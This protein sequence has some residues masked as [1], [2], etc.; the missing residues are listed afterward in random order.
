[1]LRGLYQ[2]ASDGG[3]DMV[4]CDYYEE[5]E[6]ERIYCPQSPREA[7]NR[8]LMKQIA[9]WGEFLPC[10]WNKL[11]KTEI[12]KKVAFPRITFSE[13][14]VIMFQVLFFCKSIGYVNKAFYHWCVIPTSVSRNKERGLKNML[15][16][17][18]MDVQ[19]LLFMHENKIG[20]DDEYKTGV[21]KRI[22]ESGYLCSDN[23]KML[24]AYKDAFNV[25]SERIEEGIGT[26]EM[27]AQEEEKFIR[28]IERLK[29]LYERK[30]KLIGR[31]VHFI[32]Q[33]VKNVVKKVVKRGIPKFMKGAIKKIVRFF[34]K[35]WTRR[36]DGLEERQ[37]GIDGR[38]SRIEHIE[39][40][41]RVLSNRQ[42]IDYLTI[43]NK[44][45]KDAAA[46]R[47]KEAVIQYLTRHISAPTVFPY[48]FVE[49]YRADTVQVFQDGDWRYVMY[50]NKRMYFPLP[51]TKEGG[52][53]NEEGIQAYF[54]QIFLEQDEESPHRYLTEEFT[55]NEGDIVAD[56][57]AAEGVFAL[58]VIE[59]A[60]KV[61]L[62][63]CDFHW[64]EALIKTF[65]PWA[66]K[67]EIIGKYIGDRTDGTQVSI[68]DFFAD[69]RVDFIK[70]DIEGAE[71]DL[72]R[73]A[74]RTLTLQRP[75]KMLLC[76]YHRKDDAETIEGILKANGFRTE[77]T[78][79]YMLF[80]WDEQLAAPYMRRGVIRARKP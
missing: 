68:D 44:V 52:R 34:L 19:I 51:W 75:L 12:Y 16:N 57:G 29:V 11:I 5:H 74:S 13:D 10:T 73:G 63:E 35:P 41:Q 31:P 9:T 54:N 33:A 17:Y 22:D 6:Q 21:L 42:M 36:L 24:K 79:G 71:V 43:E 50:Q 49:K 64:H 61:Y 8:T 3:Y 56:I 28:R 62:F 38:L 59:K 26:N 15:D 70:A 53:V 20:M 78:K 37:D 1:M 72:L 23:I 58:S 76:A 40:T 4:C 80:I 67:V 32:K 77:W 14:R 66:D 60:K 46:V 45:E 18:I 48:N 27:V 25:I 39:R 30:Q 2:T 69:K 55:V 7:S 47:E 65:S